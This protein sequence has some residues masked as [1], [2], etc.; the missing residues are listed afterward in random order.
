MHPNKEYKSESYKEIMEQAGEMIVEA[1]EDGKIVR[2][3]ESYAKREGLPI[4]RKS[5]MHEMQE[6]MAQ[7]G[8][9]SKNIQEEKQKLMYARPHS[10]WKDRQIISELKENFHWYVRIARKNKGLSRKQLAKLI[11]ESEESIK[12]L[13]SGILHSKDFILINKI[14]EALNINIRRDGKDYTKSLGEMIS[15]DRQDTQGK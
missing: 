9:M 4:I 2:V 7:Q 6:R 8:P 1:I 5:K 13:E 14:Q 11:N 3:P 12:L 15:K 10:N